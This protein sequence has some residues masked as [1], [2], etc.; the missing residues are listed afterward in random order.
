[1]NKRGSPDETEL[2]VFGVSSESHVKVFATQPIHDALLV[3]TVV[4]DVV[5]EDAFEFFE[6]QLL[7]QLRVKNLNLLKLRLVFLSRRLHI[8]VFALTLVLQ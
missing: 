6:L 8:R 1:M 2:Q 4:P 5:S 7:E 3:G